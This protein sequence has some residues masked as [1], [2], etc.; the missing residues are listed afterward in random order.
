MGVQLQLSNLN[1]LKWD[2]CNR[3]TTHACASIRCTKMGSFYSCFSTACKTDN[4][5]YTPEGH[6]DFLILHFARD[7]INW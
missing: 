7:A 2:G 4:E 3:T 6:V 1:V 5:K